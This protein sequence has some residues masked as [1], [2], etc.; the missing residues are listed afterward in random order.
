MDL[1]VTARRCAQQL[2]GAAA[3]GLLALAGA[4]VLDV[5]LRYAFA[6]PIRGFIDVLGLAGALLLAACMPHV[7]ASRGNIAIDL[8][9]KRLPAGAQRALDRL[10]ALATT[11]FFAAMAWQMLGFALEA[12]GTG[13]TTAVL[14]WP[15]WPWWLAVAACIALAALA[16]L[17]TAR[18][19]PDAANE[20]DA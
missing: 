9:G 13:E 17:A 20:V 5:L 7:V 14:R 12:R 19:P 4:T 16:G 18:H 11:A 3:F 15:V 10:A 8:L 6:A 2:A 1:A